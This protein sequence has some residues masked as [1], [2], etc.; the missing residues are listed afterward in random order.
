MKSF[1]QWVEG[2]TTNIIGQLAEIIGNV[3]G[4]ADVEEPPDEVRKIAEFWKKVAHTIPIEVSSGKIRLYRNHKIDA[5]LKLDVARPTAAQMFKASEF[6][7]SV[8][9]ALP[10]STVSSF[11]SF[12]DFIAVFEIPTEKLLQAARDGRAILGNIGEQEIVLDPTFAR[13]YVKEIRHKNEQGKI[14][15]DTDA[16]RHLPHDP[17]AAIDAIYDRN[18]R[19]ERKRKKTGPFIK[20]RPATDATDVIDSDRLPPPPTDQKNQAPLI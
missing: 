4:K 5:L 2:N 20:S 6:S 8:I 18:D 10:T 1:V 3:D 15:T 13:N 11:W 16:T 14:D 17:K 9:N 7:G 19:N 12:G